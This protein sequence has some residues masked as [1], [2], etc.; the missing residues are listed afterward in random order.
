MTIYEFLF[1]CIWNENCIVLCIADIRDNFIIALD[2]CFQLENNCNH[3]TKSPVC[4][5]EIELYILQVLKASACRVQVGLDWN[6]YKTRKWRW[7]YALMELAKRKQLMERSMWC[8][9]KIDVPFEFRWS[10]VQSLSAMAT[11]GH[12]PSWNRSCHSN[13]IEMKSSFTSIYQV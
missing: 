6:M 10:C 13:R 8:I 11:T 5:I 9:D 2:C 3:C 4:N 1:H 12:A 7:F